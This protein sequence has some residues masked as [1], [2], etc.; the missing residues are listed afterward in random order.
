MRDP[1][2]DSPEFRKLIAGDGSADLTRVAL[3]VARDARPGLEIDAEMRRIDALAGRARARIG[4]SARPRQVLGHIN[5]VL[6]VEESFRGDTEGYYDPANSFLDAV[7]ARKLGIPISLSIL[8]LALADRLS[9]PMAGVNLPAHF[10]VRTLEDDPTFVD[11]FHEGALLDARGCER[12]VE[13]ATG[14]A[15]RLGESSLAPCPTPTLVARMLRNLKAV[16]LRDHRYAEVLPFLRRLVALDPSP[17]ER[18]DLGV[19]CARSDLPGES[20]AH[21]RAYLDARPEADDAGTVAELL[22]GAT[23]EVASRN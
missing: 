11:P 7:I 18:R 10:V 15:V 20:M 9:L 21:L 19:L 23:R 1:F 17:L 3:E 12:L 5:W 22:R 6:F 13:Q 8:Y 14:Q 2:A 16:Y 4:P